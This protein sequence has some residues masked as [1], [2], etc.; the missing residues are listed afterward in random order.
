MATVKVYGMLSFFRTLP[1]SSVCFCMTS[2]FPQQQMPNWL[3]GGYQTWHSWPSSSPTVAPLVTMPA[4]WITKAQ[5]RQRMERND[6]HDSNMEILRLPWPLNE[7]THKDKDI[8]NR[9]CHIHICEQMHMHNR[10]M[11]SPAKSIYPVI[12]PH[13]TPW[14]PP[15]PSHWAFKHHKGDYTGAKILR[16]Q[17]INAIFKAR[18]YMSMDWKG[19]QISIVLYSI[20]YLI[21]TSSNKLFSVAFI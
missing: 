2:L 12:A 10:T 4:T 7:G 18:I 5:C 17:L 3:G 8:K 20:H 14:F 11:K 16:D 13:N 15:P 6:G 1:F 9:C 21:Y 19:L